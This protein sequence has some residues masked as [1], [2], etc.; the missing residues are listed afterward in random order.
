MEQ[1]NDVTKENN[2][3]TSESNETTINIPPTNNITTTTT[4]T[5]NTNIN[6]NTNKNT[7]TNTDDSKTTTNEENEDDSSYEYIQG[8]RICIIIDSDE[9][10]NRA[11]NKALET[12]DKEKDE[13]YL[14]AVTSS[15]DY[16]NDEKNDA[17]L[18]LYKYEHYFDS[19]GIEYTPI[20][21]ESISITSKIISELE[22][23]EID[24]A[25]VGA[26]ALTNVSNPDNIIF[27]AFSFIKQVFLGTIVSGLKSASEKK[28]CKWKLEIVN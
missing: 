2:D 25:Y 23:N 1:P 8:Q 22:E 3:N 4:T 26:Q 11:L 24:L 17:K 21:V 27:S 9:S 19:I 20:Q 28:D 16:L 13:L 18:T 10:T 6:T 14:L 15:L 5:T 7:N 12:F